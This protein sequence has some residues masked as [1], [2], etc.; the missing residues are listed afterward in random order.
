MELV[1]I[2]GKE[3]LR[4]SSENLAFDVMLVK[5]VELIWT[6]DP[7]PTSR[8]GSPGSSNKRVKIDRSKVH[9][10]ERGGSRLFNNAAQSAYTDTKRKEL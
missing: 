5:S 3:L 8:E 4:V 9:V 10:K 1:L 2:S 7:A 6:A